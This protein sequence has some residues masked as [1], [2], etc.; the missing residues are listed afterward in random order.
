M[1]RNNNA[2]LIA[3]TANIVHLGVIYRTKN[4]IQEGP[5]RVPP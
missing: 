5:F 4:V 1:A 2:K 3:S